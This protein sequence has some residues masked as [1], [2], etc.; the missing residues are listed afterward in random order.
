M[1]EKMFR[2]SNN[3]NE[4]IECDQIEAQINLSSR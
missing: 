3:M 1:C 2:H 4:P